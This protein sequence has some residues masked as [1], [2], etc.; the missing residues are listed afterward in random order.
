MRRHEEPPSGLFPASPLLQS[1]GF[2]SICFP[3][4]YLIPHSR[5][6]S[7][8]L[9]RPIVGD[10]WAV[11]GKAILVGGAI[12]IYLRGNIHDK[13]F[14]LTDTLPAMEDSIGNLDQHRIVNTAAE[15]VD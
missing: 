11:R 12:G 9:S 14:S 1:P 8:I 5:Q 2:D 4:L 15:F 13:G 7:S 10:I 3:P 6:K